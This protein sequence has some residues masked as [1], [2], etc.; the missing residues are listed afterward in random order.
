MWTAF[1]F[2]KRFL[3]DLYRAIIFATVE[4]DENL[5]MTKT[6]T[7]RMIIW[8]IISI[9]SCLLHVDCCMQRGTFLMQ[10][11]SASSKCLFEKSHHQLS[12]F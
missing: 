2:L 1:D 10:L 6:T 7:Q 4:F 9:V 12:L 11:K 5:Q 8:G 3:Y